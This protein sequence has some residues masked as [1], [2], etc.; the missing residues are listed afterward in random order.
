MASIAPELLSEER[1]HLIQRL[2]KG[3]GVK[4]VDSATHAL[5]WLGDLDRLRWKVHTMEESDLWSEAIGNLKNPALSRGAVKAWLAHSGKRTGQTAESIELTKEPTKEPTEEPTKGAAGSSKIPQKRK[6]GGDS[7]GSPSKFRLKRSIPAKEIARERDNGRCI[8]TKM[9]EPIQVYHIYPFAL[10]KK[11]ESQRE[12]FWLLLSIFWSS[13]TIAKWKKELMGGENPEVPQNLLCLSSIV[14][15]LWGSARLAFKPIKI[16]K[17]K[18]SLTMQFWW[19]PHREYSD[20]VALQVAPS[21]PSN[22]KASPLNAKLWDCDTDQPIYSG[23]LITMTTHDP[24]AMPLPSLDLLHM[25]W[26][27]NR[28][29]AMSG[30]ADVMDEDFEDD[31]EGLGDLVLEPLSLELPERPPRSRESSK[32]REFAEETSDDA[33]AFIDA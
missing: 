11:A 23:Q 31:L 28:V 26:M 27:L 21:L 4:Y 9:G 10:G 1:A 7:S 25:Q 15:D 29:A 16:S 24:V 20:R 14:H 2:S 18:T 3:T 5:L 17:D 6:S 19:L 8:V 30:A 12:D 33:F 22:L 13:K 32:I